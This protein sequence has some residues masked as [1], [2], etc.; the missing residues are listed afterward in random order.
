MSYT[1]DDLIDLDIVQGLRELG[2]DDGDDF[3]K[4][5]IELYKE[6]YPILLAQMKNHLSNED[7]PN[8]SKSAHALKG[9]SLNIGAKELASVCKTIEINAKSEIQ[10][11][12]N[13]LISD[14]E[15][16]HSLTFVELEK[17]LN[18]V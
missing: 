10:Q 17:L 16:I 14:L 3:I 2:G 7:Y 6:Q 1:K 8:L 13:D 11:G 5:I 15:T 18:M 12:F 4:E 9:A